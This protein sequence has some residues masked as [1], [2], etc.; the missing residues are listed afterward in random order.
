M[1]IDI[2]DWSEFEHRRGIGYSGTITV[3]GV[4]TCTFDN[5][6]SFIVDYIIYHGGKVT[7]DLLRCAM[8]RWDDEYDSIEGSITSFSGRWEYEPIAV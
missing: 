6:G 1:L 4:K 8:K 5:D 2:V 7:K 3:D